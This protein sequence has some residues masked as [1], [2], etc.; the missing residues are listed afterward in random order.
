LPALLIQLER[1][2]FRLAQQAADYHPGVDHMR[3]WLAAEVLSGNRIGRAVS[4]CSTSVPVAQPI[5]PKGI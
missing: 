4:F 2:T 5:D 3:A 1:A